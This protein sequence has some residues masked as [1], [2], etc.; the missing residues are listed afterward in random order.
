MITFTAGLWLGGLIALDLIEAPTKFKIKSIERSA[1]VELGQAVFRKFGYVEMVLSLLLVTQA[2]S[3]VPLYIATALAAIALIISPVVRS[4][5]I[6]LLQKG[7][8][9]TLRLYHR[10]YV[11]LDISKMLLLVA[12]VVVVSI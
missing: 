2:A 1:A 5:L 9:D 3:G 6:T 10:V 8:K 7:Q 4:H 12:L 11:V